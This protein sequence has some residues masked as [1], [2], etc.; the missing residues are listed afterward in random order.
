VRKNEAGTST[1]YMQSALLK[2]LQKTRRKKIGKQSKTWTF[3]ISYLT[4]YQESSWGVK[5][6]GN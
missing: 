6:G 3:F 4:T 1:E 2:L 5:G